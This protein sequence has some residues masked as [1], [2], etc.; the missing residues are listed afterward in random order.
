MNH[1]H[2]GTS[3]PERESVV[4][5]GE[6]AVENRPATDA[7]GLAFHDVSIDVPTSWLHLVEGFSGHAAANDLQEFACET[8]ASST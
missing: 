2:S 6:H 5:F 3:S 8:K 1:D 4:A 7:E